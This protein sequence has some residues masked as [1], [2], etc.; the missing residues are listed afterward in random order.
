M[1]EKV[2]CKKCRLLINKDEEICPYCGFDQKEEIKENLTD[3]ISHP[4]RQELELLPNSKVLSFPFAKHLALFLLGFIGLSIFNLI[5][6][7]LIL[8][9]SNQDYL[10]SLGGRNLVVSLSYLLTFLTMLLVIF[11]DNLKL[12]K[13]FISEYKTYLIG[14]LF[15]GALILFSS[16]YNMMIFNLGFNENNNQ[17]LVVDIV[18]KFPVSSV[19]IIGIIGPIVEELTY[20]IG[21]Y[22]LIRKY[23]RVAAFIVTSLIFGLIHFSVG[24]I[25]DSKTLVN[26]LVNLPS[27]I[28]SG[29]ILCFA[30]EKFGIS[31]S[32]LAHITNN[33]VGVIVYIIQ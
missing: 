13:I 15:G 30:Y 28:I 7:S 18:K 24:S 22:S 2:K 12:I 10:T 17:N 8:A 1:K 20:R 4:K 19:F 21:L 9:F 25:E 3:N 32:V 31:G 6:Q 11:K 14:I 23:N 26:E 29:L 33:L 5:I 27:Y 16:L